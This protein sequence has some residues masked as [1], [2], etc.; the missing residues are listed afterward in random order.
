MA[1]YYVHTSIEDGI[2]VPELAKLAT[3]S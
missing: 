2:K 3:Q 1:I